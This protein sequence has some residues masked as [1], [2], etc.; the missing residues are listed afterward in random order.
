MKN[1]N[2]QKIIKIAATAELWEELAW[3]SRLYGSTKAEYVREAIRRL[4]RTVK[5]ER[6]R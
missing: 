2:R 5:E 3:C 1:L 6:I 4:N